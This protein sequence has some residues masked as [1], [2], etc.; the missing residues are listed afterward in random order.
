MKK[1]QEQ[2]TIADIPLRST[3]RLYFVRVENEQPVDE[4]WIS[5]DEAKAMNA[6]DRR[7]HGSPQNRYFQDAEAANSFSASL[8]QAPI[9]Q[10][11]P[12]E[13]A[14]DFGAGLEE[15]DM[16]AGLAEPEFA[17]GDDMSLGGEDEFDMDADLDMGLDDVDTGLGDDDGLGDLSGELG[18]DEPS[19]LEI[20]VP[21]QIKLVPES[22]EQPE[23]PMSFEDMVTKAE[24]F[25][26]PQF[27]SKM[28]NK[29]AK[30]KRAKR[31]ASS[32]DES[33]EAGVVEA[34]LN[35]DITVEAAVSHQHDLSEG[36]DA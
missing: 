14:A 12:T 16:G 23:K 3:S 26:P 17:P 33:T 28:D 19:V 35:G 25:I 11:P 27:R 15:P 6:T 7:M 5:V 34:L 1:V 2:G 36:D 9:D 29:A 13:P 10:M 20:R 21:K 22:L 4:G 24:S 32:K 30:A 8:G 18:A 31:K